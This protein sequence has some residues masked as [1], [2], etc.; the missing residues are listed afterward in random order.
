MILNR[1]FNHLFSKGIVYD[2]YFFLMALKQLDYLQNNTLTFHFFCMMIY[3]QILVSTSN[4]P[5][6]QLYEGGLQRDLFLPFIDTLKVR[7]VRV[8]QFLCCQLSFNCCVLMLFLCGPI[9]GK[10]HCAPHWL[11]SRL[12]SIGFSMFP[13]FAGC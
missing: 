2:Y 5:P 7:I 6:D 13:T 12:S 3:S 8:C 4:H 9:A 10:V 1:L 11:C